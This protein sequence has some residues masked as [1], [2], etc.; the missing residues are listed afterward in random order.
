VTATDGS[1][2]IRYA[3]IPYILDTDLFNGPHAGGCGMNF[4][5]AKN[6]AFGN[7]IFDGFS[8]VVGHEYAEAVTDPDNTL[9]VQD[10]WN[11]A[12][13]SENGDKCAW[14]A[15]GSGQGASQNL[16]LRTGTFAVQS[17]WSNAFDGGAGGCVV[18]YP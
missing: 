12:Q 3:Y 8:I 5:N 2:G 14:N 9:G 10:G 16:R 6:T 17:M 7:G 15:P 4:V 13:T 1:A 18:S 11:D